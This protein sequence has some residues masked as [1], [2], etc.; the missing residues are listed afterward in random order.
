MSLRTR[1]LVF[2][3][4]FGS[5]LAI[6]FLLVSLTTNQWVRAF[7]RRGNSTNSKGEVNYGLF[8]GTKELN[9]GFG[10]RPHA[11]NVYT[12]ITTEPQSMNFWLWLITTLGTGFGLL[13]CA[14]G[15]IASVLKAASASK[16]PGT[17]LL[18]FASNISS[19]FAQVLAFV[20]WLI[21][22]FQYL[23][24]NVLA[25]DDHKRQWYSRGLAH[26]GYS[27]YM[28]IASTL[29]VFLNIFVL[30]YA[31]RCEKGEER[32]LDPT[33]YSKNQSAIMLY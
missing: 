17:M 12:F 26:L 8:Y 11:V 2:S 33:T 16:K 24:H 5:C 7:P 13:G 14:I 21:Q 3:T 23:Q 31:K 29:V 18:L 20:C 32:K 30:I 4:F 25:L 22:F 6:G 1:A 15:A 28:V 10:F 9:S 19:A 27:F